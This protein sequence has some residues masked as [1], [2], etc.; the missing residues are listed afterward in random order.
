M[1][2]RTLKQLFLYGFHAILGSRFEN[3]EPN[4]CSEK[5]EKK[6]VDRLAFLSYFRCIINIRGD[7][8]SLVLCSGYNIIGYF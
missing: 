8:D 2:H 7:C 5:E 4:R 3:N 6:E 1:L